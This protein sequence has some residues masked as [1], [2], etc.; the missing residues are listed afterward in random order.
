MP[1]KRQALALHTLVAFV[2]VCT[3]LA[4]GAT[5]QTA[6]PKE[7]PA[8]IS[9]RVR[10]E[11][12]GVSGI[13][14]ALRPAEGGPGTNTVARSKTDAEG[15][16]RLNGVAP[17][18]YYVQPSAPGYVVG[19]TTRDWM[20][21]SLITLGPGESV[22][23][24]NFTLSR[25][26]VITGRVVDGDGR[27]VVGES[28]Q[29]VPQ[30]QSQ[31]TRP[32]FIPGANQTDDRGVYR[33]YGLPAGRYKVSVGVE[34][35]G[36]FG[37]FVGGRARGYYVRTY[38][39]DATDAA[40]AKIVELTEGGEATEVDITVGRLAKSFRVSGRVIDATGLPAPNV[41]FSYGVYTPEQKQRLLGGGYRSRTNAQGEFQIEGLL[42][43]RYAAY[44]DPDDSAN[45]YSNPV[46]F[47]IADADVSGL[48]VRLRGGSTLAGVVAIEGVV[49][50]AL[51]ARL[52]QRLT[53]FIN[54]ETLQGR[55]NAI[56][57]NPDGSFQTA[58][59]K[60]GKARISVGYPPVKGLTL[61]RVELNGVEQRD[62][63]E[64]AE[65]SRVMGVRVVFQYG[66]GR[67]RGEI[68][69]MENG[70]PAT[71][72]E[73]GRLHLFRR[74]AGA[75]QSRYLFAAIPDSR[76]RFLIE[77]LPS[78]AVELMAQAV[79]RRVG[80]A[81]QIISVPDDGEVN[82]TLTIEL[83]QPAPPRPRPRPQP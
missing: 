83:A 65:G 41:F 7:Q 11:E 76:G 64:V 31:T 60:P 50:R 18:R 30:E 82:V 40:Q 57:V 55:R 42:P 46:P 80:Q 27:P 9:G 5:G 21:Q 45:A 69:L 28:V 68:V 66:T 23:E 79:G 78:G 81:N 20:Q 29:F 1:I 49:D 3:A 36:R 71:L 48:V 62:G 32:T 38:H 2:L 52:L 10:L 14:V 13:T 67:I 33:L 24:M 43:G 56:R 70:Q 54:D 61:A 74:P 26:A 72:P 12:R 15:F 8:S 77:N 75:E 39:P 25:G 22:E 37:N 58:G 19:A 44:A 63:I 17:G 73:G 53:L 35:S 59:L 6:R 16:Y 4:V 51:A 47:E 34:T